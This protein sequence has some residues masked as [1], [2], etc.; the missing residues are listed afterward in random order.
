M[1]LRLHERSAETHFRLG[2]GLRYRPYGGDRDGAQVLTPKVEVQS[3]GVH[4]VL[5]NRLSGNADYSIGYSGGRMGWNVPAGESE[6]V[7]N[8]PLGRRG[9]A[10]TAVPGE[11]TKSVR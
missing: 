10:A 6:R 9:S 1:D 7:A 5:D 2:Q 3:A 4:L 8:V 11:E